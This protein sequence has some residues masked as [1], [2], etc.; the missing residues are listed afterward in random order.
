MGRSAADVAFFLSAI[1]GPDPQSPLSINE[2]GSLFARP[3]GRNFKGVKIAWCEA[4]AGL[5][6]DRRVT[7]VF[8]ACR[9]KL[10]S[11]GCIVETADPD[12]SGADEC[13]KV[14][15]ALAFYQNHAPKLAQHRDQLKDT[16]I[17]EIER[18]S[19]LTGPEIAHAEMLRAALYSRIATL[20]EKYEY[21]VLPTTQVPAFAFDQPYVKEI[22]GV[23]FASYIDWMRSCYYVTLLALPAISTPAG[24]TPE[25]LPVGLQIVGRHQADFSVLQLAHAFE[26]ANPLGRKPGLN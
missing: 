18:G 8:N 22:E 6:F 14:F 4:F 17:E 9:T 3:L 20:L 15:R 2:P 10:E 19:R 23:K 25:G 24:F 21:F 16:V 7:G 11:T 1:A 26:L 12:F 5:P 13:F